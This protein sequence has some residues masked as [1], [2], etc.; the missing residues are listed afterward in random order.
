[1]NGARET[2]PTQRLSNGAVEVHAERNLLVELDVCAHAG[3]VG[4]GAQPR[5]QRHLLDALQ[6]ISRQSVSRSVQTHTKKQQQPTGPVE[7]EEECCT[8][9]AAQRRTLYRRRGLGGL[10]EPPHALTPGQ[11]EQDNCGGLHL[12][13]LMGLGTTTGRTG[14]DEKRRRGKRRERRLVESR[15]YEDLFKS[16]PFGLLSKRKKQL[17][18]SPIFPV[19]HLPMAPSHT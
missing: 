2:T 8:T 14:G 13:L 7:R 1:M 18:S 16:V 4:D 19:P 10:G 11:H 15:W 3:G 5:R 17:L 12:S 6:L 9:Y